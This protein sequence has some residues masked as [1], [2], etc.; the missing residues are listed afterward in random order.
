MKKEIKQ[1]TS[2]QPAPAPTSRKLG[3]GMEAGDWKK[4]RMLQYVRQPWPRLPP[5]MGSQMFW[6]CFASSWWISGQAWAEFFEGDCGVVLVVG[7]ESRFYFQGGQHL[8]TTQ[9]PW[10][11]G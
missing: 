5:D 6:T 3:R 9:Q 11:L 7:Q 10:E 4:E 2:K 1:G 8:V